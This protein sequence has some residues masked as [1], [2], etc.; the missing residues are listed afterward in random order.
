MAY[1]EV[2]K[3]F[4]MRKGKAGNQYLRWRGVQLLGSKEVVYD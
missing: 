4:P 2:R 1:W 3:L